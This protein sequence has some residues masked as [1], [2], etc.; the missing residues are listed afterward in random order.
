MPGFKSVFGRGVRGAV[1][2][3][4]SPILRR[5]NEEREETARRIAACEREVSRLRKR[6]IAVQ[7]NSRGV[8]PENMIWMFGVAR[9]GSSWL[10]SMMAELNGYAMWFEPYVG[11]VF[12]FSYNIRSPEWQRQRDDFLLSDRYRD[13]WLKSIRAFV[14]EGA[15]A[16]FP[17]LGEDG[18]LVVK[19]P[20]GSIGAPLLLEAMPESREI[21]LVRDPR[22]VV[23]SLLDANRKG[24]WVANQ[25]GSAVGGNSLADTD[26]DTFVRQRAGMYMSSMGKAKEAHDAHEGPKVVVRYEDLQR[27]T[28]HEMKKMYD[29]LG[30]SFDEIQ[31]ARAVERHAWEKIP[32]ANKGAGKFHRKG[33][34]GG[35][36]EDLTPEQARIVEEITAPL[37]HE[38]YIG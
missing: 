37:L 7:T 17:D 11:D 30:I 16:R 26:P 13:A 36:R 1:G 33:V 10:A 35:W 27:D 5:K 19:E 9:T 14:L 22:D 28:L 4:V 8:K 2:R 38:F 25:N 12:G 18:Y 31:L 20:N 3:V 32:D 29:A 21:L 15:D 6:L 23:A 24:G 34:A